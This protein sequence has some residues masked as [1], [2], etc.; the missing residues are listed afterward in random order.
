LDEKHTRQIRTMFLKWCGSEPEQME[1][2]PV[3]GSSRIYFRLSTLE[4]SAVAVYNDDIRENEAFISYGRHFKEKRLPV[5]E[6][7]GV[8]DDKATYLQEDLGDHTLFSFIKDNAEKGDYPPEAV[9]YYQRVLEW[10]PQFQI[11]GHQGLDY[12]KAYPRQA[13]DEQSMR[14]D[15]NYFKYYFLKLAN[16]SFDEQELENDYDTFVKFLLNAPSDYF[17]YRDFQSRNIMIKEG[18]PYFID[19]QGGR[20]GA[21]QYDLASLLYDAKAKIPNDIRKMLF[22]HYLNNLKAMKHVDD[23]LFIQYY[24]GFVLIRIM[25]AMGAYGFRGFYER[26]THFLQSIPPALN[27]LRFLLG[28]MDSPIKIPHLNS[29]LNDLVDA[30]A[31]KKYVRGFYNKNPLNIE[32]MSF[33]YLKGL[34][35]D[36]HGNGGGFLFDCRCIHNPGRYERYKHLNGRDN[37]VKEFLKQDGE[38]D[39]FLKHAYLMVE[40]AV[41]KYLDRNFEHLFI[42]FGCTGGQHRSVYCTE[43]MK[44]HLKEKYGDQVQIY[45]KHR[46]QEIEEK[47]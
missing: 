13:F 44:N 34:P 22:D 35:G 12:S 38:A 24:H 15:L 41:E 19:F 20:R 42:G 17:L 8:S 21:L 25:Q 28:E 43:E 7:Y 4:K 18:Q 29:V 30:P 47:I 36:K 31:L 9:L 2:M 40:Q 3:S 46:E 32:L 27:N 14:W 33:S 10:L 5:P 39:E 11:N 23:D 45:L 37:E 16:I 6:I 26:K 1:R